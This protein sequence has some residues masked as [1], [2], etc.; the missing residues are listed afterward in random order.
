M[1]FYDFLTGTEGDMVERGLILAA[2][3]RA[4]WGFT[5]A[6]VPGGSAGKLTE[7]IW[8]QDPTDKLSTPK[9]KSEVPNINFEPLKNALAKL[10]NS[11]AEYQKAAAGKQLSASERK[12]LD[13]ILYKSERLLTRSEGLPR[14][15]WFR[16]KISAPGFYT[17]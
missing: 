3:A 17:G 9:L 12:T 2:L 16:H 10:K 14:R 15:D 11:A 1:S 8:V 6:Y 5:P 4:A 7:T 13:D